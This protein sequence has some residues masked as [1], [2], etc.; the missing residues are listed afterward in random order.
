MPPTIC[1]GFSSPFLLSS[2]GKAETEGEKHHCVRRFLKFLL[3]NSAERVYFSPI[4]ETLSK[5]K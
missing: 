5:L 4:F 3:T 2:Q 1:A